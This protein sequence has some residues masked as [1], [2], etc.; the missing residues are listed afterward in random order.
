MSFFLLLFVKAANKAEMWFITNGINGGISA[1]VGDAF[2]EERSS[3]YTDSSSGNLS[4][5]PYFSSN[6]SDRKPLTLI[7]IVS[8]SSLQNSSSFDGT[9]KNVF[10]FSLSDR[11]LK[12]M[13]FFV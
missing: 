11:S 3:R 12:K 6:Q 2:S 8:A 1:M 9:V 5:L 13:Y 7:G 4:N 10:I